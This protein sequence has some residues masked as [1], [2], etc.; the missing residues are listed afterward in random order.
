MAEIFFERAA[1][2]GG[3]PILGARHASLERLLARDVLRVLELARVDAQVAVGRL[4]QALQIVERE[5]LVHRQ[6]ADDAKPQPLVDQAIE[7]ERA[8]LRRLN[9]KLLTSNF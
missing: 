9:F 1:A 7:L 4:Q 3:Q 6:R 2:G 5:P 8:P